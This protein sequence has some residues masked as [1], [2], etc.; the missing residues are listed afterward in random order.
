VLLLLGLVVLLSLNT[1]SIVL[2]AASLIPIAIYPFM[3]RITDWPQAFLGFTFNWGALLGWS[4]VMDG[5]AL[6]VALK[7]LP[8]AC[9]WPVVA[10]TASS[11]A[12]TREDFLAQG[13]NDYIAKPYAFAE[14]LRA[15]RNHGGAHLQRRDAPEP[16]AT[17]T[18][19][20]D[21]ALQADELNQ[22]V[23]WAQEGRALELR[24]WL[25]LKPA[26]PPEAL[27]AVRA[28]LARYD[29]QSVEAVLQAQRRT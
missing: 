12:L 19:R 9:G 25:D 26:L 28:A 24:Q 14:V 3:K 22:A 1:F 2:G 4:A 5:L 10:I 23:Q 6:R 8:H 11:L 13:F 27:D 17:P 7:S 20:N 21:S 18:A 15:L 16:T 29:L